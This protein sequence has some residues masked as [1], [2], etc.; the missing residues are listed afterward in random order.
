MGVGGHFW[1]M[2]KPYARPEGSDFLRNKWVA[3][4]LS[5]WI[6]Q[7]E[8]AIKTHVRNPHLRLTF[9]RTINL[10]SKVLLNFYF[11][12]TVF[13]AWLPRK[14]KILGFVVHG[15]FSMAFYGDPF[16]CLFF[17]LNTFCLF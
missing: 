2:L 7:H 13:L 15:V 17:C 16:V 14:L 11:L 10:F 5:I 4:D 3:V 8:T 9:F 6:V 1:D 12:S